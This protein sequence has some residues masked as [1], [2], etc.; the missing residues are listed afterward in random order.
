MPYFELCQ[1]ITGM[2]LRI[3]LC[4]RMTG[5][6]DFSPGIGTLVSIPA[7][8]LEDEASQEYPKRT[9][10]D[11]TLV[12]QHNFRFQKGKVG[13]SDCDHRSYN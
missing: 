8:A 13:P 7:C 2:N 1:K 11:R 12:S 10:F 9:C 5:E 3:L 6:I 4:A